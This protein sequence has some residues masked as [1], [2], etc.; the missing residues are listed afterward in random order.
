[1]PTRNERARKEMRYSDAKAVAEQQSS[2]FTPT[3]F[4]VPEGMSLFR[5]KQVK[6]YNLD[7]LPYVV[8]KGNPRA[9]EGILH[10]E[11]TYYVHSRIGP[12]ND[13]YACLAKNFNKKCPI[14][15]YKA[16]L[17]MDPKTKKEI[18]KALEPKVRQLWLVRDRDDLEKGVQ[19]FEAAFFKSWGELIKSK[20]KAGDEDSPYQNFFHLDDGMYLKVTVEED[21]YDG[22]KF[23][24]PTN[25]EMRPR[26][27]PLKVSILDK[28]P[29]LDELLI[30][31][32]FKELKEIF[33]QISS[34]DEEEEDDDDV[35]DGSELDEEDDD[36]SDVDGDE[37]GDDED[38]KPTKSK[39][40]NKKKKEE[41]DDE[42]EEDDD[43]EDGD[44][45]DDEDP[46]PA[47]KAG[48]SSKKSSK[49]DDE[50]VLD[51]EGDDSDGD[52]GSDDDDSEEDDDGDGD[53][54]G[55][56]EVKFGKGDRVSGVY[57][58][59][60]FKGKVIRIEKRKGK[61]D[62]VTV[63]TDGDNTRV[64]D[65]GELT[66]LKAASKKVEEDDEGEDE[67]EKKPSK[68]SKTSSKKSSSKGGKPKK[69]DEDDE[70]DDIP[71]DDEDGEED[72]D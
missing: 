19:L 62:L 15:Q 13:S 71:F 30:E 18:L 24:K 54:E 11:R 49:K 50:D 28:C 25:I 21:S 53:D 69:K 31:K 48:K 20:I 47:R 5:F 38:E 63:K 6:T 12:N 52:D 68:T 1:M 32:S 14:C 39:K 23:F 64:M 43:D 37:D 46:K 56:D 27:K 36:D 58:S 42:E 51:D 26:Q 34:E 70:D 72:D 3:A 40:T 4:S 57:K 29:C 67:E 44:E 16:K 65:A 35:E 60:K 45:D 8:G 55:G 41:D 9:D 61:D 2:G 22:R 33:L 66:L 59:K 7:V 10:F 17:G